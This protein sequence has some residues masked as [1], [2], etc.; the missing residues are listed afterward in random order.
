[1]AS[2]LLRIALA[3]AAPACLRGRPTN[4]RSGGPVLVPR[5]RTACSP[6]SGS[7]EQEEQGAG[8]L[9]PARARTPRARPQRQRPGTGVA[10]AVEASWATAYAGSGVWIADGRDCERGGV[11]ASATE[12]S[13]AGSRP[14][15]PG[16]RRATGGASRRSSPAAGAR[17]T[18]R[19][20]DEKASATAATPGSETTAARWLRQ[21][22]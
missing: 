7:G 22:L 4:L 6:V 9:R 3:F 13:A 11:A 21:S 10:G 19:P 2:G 12:S 20:A 14:S 1:M 16:R 17:A 8:G 15:A 18:A 5:L